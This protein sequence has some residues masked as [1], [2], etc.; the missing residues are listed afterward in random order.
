M[1]AWGEVIDTAREALQQPAEGIATPIHIQ[2]APPTGK[3][4]L[5]FAFAGSQNMGVDAAL[6]LHTGSGLCTIMLQSKLHKPYGTDVFTLAL[7]QA[8]KDLKRH[9]FTE[10]ANILLGIAQLVVPLSH[11]V[12]LSNFTR[13]VECNTR[14]WSRLWQLFVV[15]CG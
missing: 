14:E 2:P 3:L 7:D 11:A 12:Y 10:P 13:R 15:C 9:G 6:M 5:A 8:R 4:P 1:Q